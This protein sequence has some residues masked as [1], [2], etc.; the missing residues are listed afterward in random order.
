[1]ERKKEKYMFGKDNDKEIK[2]LLVMRFSAMGDVA[3]TVPVLKA[4]A[5]QNPH[6]R[7]TMLTRDRFVGMYEWLPANV[8]VRGVNLAK[9]KGILGLTRLFGSLKEYDFDAVADLHDVLR[10][11]FIRTCFSVTGTKVAVVNKGREEKRELIGCGQTHAPLKRMT[12]RYVEVFQALGLNVDLTENATVDIRHENFY[13]VNKFAGKKA[14]VEKWIGVAPFAAHEQKIYPLGKMREVVQQLSKAGCKVFLF[15][16]GEHETTV[17]EEWERAS[18]QDGE[19]EGKVVSTCGKLGGLHNEMLLMS[20]LDLM[21]S[22]DSANM[23]IAS[24][25]GTRVLSIWGATHPKAGFSGYGQLP[26]S[27]MQLDLPCRPCSIYGK[28]P[29]VYGDLRCMAISP[30]AVVAKALEMVRLMVNDN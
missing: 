22:M 29:C 19:T 11:K 3:M 13:E 24:I 6:L 16:A 21:I 2:R 26:G 4:L 23:H 1:M 9:Y 18:A 28:K 14:E 10:T 15:G 27:E 25:F 5:S 8:V 30:E 20:R 17:L 7:I 12:D